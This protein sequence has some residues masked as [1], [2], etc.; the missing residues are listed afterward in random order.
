MRAVWRLTPPNAPGQHMRTYAALVAM[1]DA[2]RA[3]FNAALVAD[4]G[5]RSDWEPPS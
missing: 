1:L 4:V 2:V 5:R 3:D